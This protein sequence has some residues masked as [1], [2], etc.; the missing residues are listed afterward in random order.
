MILIVGARK[1]QVRHAVLAQLPHTRLGR[2]ARLLAEQ[3]DCLVACTGHCANG[4]TRRPQ[5]R[6]SEGDKAVTQIEVNNAVGP[7]S[8]RP[9]ERTTKFLEEIGKLCDGYDVSRRRLVFERQ[10]ASFSTIL[11]YYRTGELHLATGV[12]FRDIQSDLLYWGIDPVSTCLCCILV[13]HSYLRP[14]A[15]KHAICSLLS[16][17][18]CVELCCKRKL[19][20]GMKRCLDEVNNVPLPL[21]D[22]A[23]ELAE[24][25]RQ[26]NGGRCEHL[27]RILWRTFEYPHTSIAAKVL[28]LIQ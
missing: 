17:Q 20:R 12:C 28:L 22:A 4:Q 9:Q 23:L 24:D 1:F 18:E 27:R 10:T 16:M 8:S 13:T 2:I 11:D 26:F 15:P 5:V 7:T 21:A 25:E 14:P 6:C 19:L 3:S